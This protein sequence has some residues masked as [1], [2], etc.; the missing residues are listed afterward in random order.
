MGRSIVCVHAGL[1]CGL[2][3]YFWPVQY[4]PLSHVLLSF[5]HGSHQEILFVKI[6]KD[7]G[8]SNWH[9][10]PDASGR[11]MKP[12]EIL[13]GQG[14]RTSTLDCRRDVQTLSV[15]L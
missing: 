1:Q 2:E 8:Q 7:N 4:E 6:T 14:S 9:L 10:E 15:G 13:G 5:C 3:R 12:I 11:E